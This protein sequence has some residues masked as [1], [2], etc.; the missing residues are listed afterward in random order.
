[1]EDSRPS[2]DTAVDGRALMASVDGWDVDGEIARDE[3]RAVGHR[4]A[5]GAF[6]VVAHE[7]E[8]LP[9]GHVIGIRSAVLIDQAA[10][11]IATATAIV[12]TATATATATAAF[13]TAASM[14]AA[15]TA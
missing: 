1:M 3:A 14:A 4:A 7:H 8:R 2:R 11:A 10:I 9:L 13:P 12:P 6:E 5:V 15:G